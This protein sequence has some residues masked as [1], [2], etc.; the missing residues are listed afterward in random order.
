MG[1]PAAVKDT[2]TPSPATL[3][4]AALATQRERVRFA[5]FDYEPYADG[6][7]VASVV[8]EWEDGVRFRGRAEGTQTPQGTLRCGA[9]AAI[10][11]A[12]RATDGAIELSL[13]GVKAVRAFDH[14]VIIVAV[15]GTAEDEDYK[16]IGAYATQSD[17]SARAAA[18][19]V[20]DATNRILIKYLVQGD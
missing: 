16:L 20:L 9:N 1:Q 3:A 4:S 11:A 2:P 7:C 15:K 14:W 8:F 13:I 19:S 6:S 5:E 17:Q 10:Q 12:A 18:M